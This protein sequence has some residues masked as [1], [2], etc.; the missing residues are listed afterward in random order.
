MIRFFG[1]IILLVAAISSIYFFA[2]RIHQAAQKPPEIN[3]GRTYT[4]LESVTLPVVKVVYSDKG[5]APNTII[6]KKG[7]LVGFYNRTQY[8]KMWVATDPHPGHNEYPGFDQLQDG[9]DYFYV[10]TKEGTW[11]YHNH[12]GADDRGKIIV[13]P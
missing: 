11:K 4:A 10:F 1:I 12:L 5:F 6:I 2:Y 8:K 7:T 9:N 3:A 13:T